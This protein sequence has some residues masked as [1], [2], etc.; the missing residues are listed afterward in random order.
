[1]KP[2]EDESTGIPGFRTWRK[3]YL[4]VAGLFLAWVALLAA[5]ALLYS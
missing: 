4:G 2:E 5:A 3:V 1:M